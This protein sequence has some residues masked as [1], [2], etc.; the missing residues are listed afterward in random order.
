[1]KKI[2]K[3]FLI[4]S[5]LLFCTQQTFAVQTLDE[6][7]EEI[8]TLYTSNN[9]EQAHKQISM[10]TE[11]ERDYE[12]WFLLGNISQD[13]NNEENSIFYLQ[14]SIKLK[15]DFDKAH[16]NLANIY[17]NQKKYNMAIK[18]YKEAIK[19]KKDFPYYYYNLA[20]A[21]I[22]QKEYKEAKTMLK[23]AIKLKKEADFYYNLAF[24]NK[25]LKKEKEYTQALSEYEKLKG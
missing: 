5:I 3:L 13:L 16:Y 24:V 14:K 15:P 11:N 9:I 23:K 18:E 2:L 12:T 20:C 17:F 25:Q 8:F 19:H 4:C 10:L 1:M 7:K 22:A 6:K 21:Y